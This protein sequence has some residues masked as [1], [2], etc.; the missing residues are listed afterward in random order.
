MNN[1]FHLAL[2]TISNSRLFQW[3]SLPQICTSNVTVGKTFILAHWEGKAE[4]YR[5]ISLLEIQIFTCGDIPPYP[6][7]IKLMTATETIQ[8]GNALQKSIKQTSKQSLQFN[9]DH[10]STS[11]IMCYLVLLLKANGQLFK[12]RRGTI[13]SAFKHLS[14]LG[15]YNNTDFLP[16][17]LRLQLPPS[18]WKGN[19]IIILYY[20][21][22]I[23]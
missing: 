10:S 21:Y 22:I 6:S 20:I 18:R 5:Q 3:M 15:A 12:R 4:L 14:Y 23:I 7:Q 2:N 11:W 9:S 16:W 1:N 19:M 17:F 13:N 8:L